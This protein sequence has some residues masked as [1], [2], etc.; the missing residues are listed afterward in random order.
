MP[1]KETARQSALDQSVEQAATLQRS[2]RLHEADRIYNAVLAADPQHFD[3]LHL[4]GVLKYQQGRAVEALRLVAAALAIRPAS[5]DALM[6]HGVVLEALKRHD[7]ALARFDQLLSA[8]DRDATLHYNRGKALQGLGRYAEALASYDR[9]IALAPDLGAAHQ[10]RGSTLAALDRDEDALASFDRALALVLAL[11]G[12]ATGDGISGTL[13]EG[14]AAML[15]EMDAALAADPASVDLLNNRGK[16]LFRL[17][18]HAEAIATFDRSL[19]LRSD[20]K[21]ALLGRGNALAAIDHFDAA[22]TDFLRALSI[23][24]N[25]ADAYLNLGNALVLVNR[26][27][28]ALQCFSAVLAINPENPDAHFNEGLVRLLLGD[29]RQGWHKYEYRWKRPRHEKDRPTFPQP[30]WR[31]EKDLAGRTI[32]LAPEQGLGD[33]IQF[34]RYAPLLDALGARVVVAA[35]PSLTALLATVPGVAEVITGGD[36]LPHFDLYCPLLSLPMGFE[37]ELATIPS[38]VPYIFPRQEWIDRW[39]VRSPKSSERLRVG[40]CWAGTGA[41][42]NNHRRSIAIEQFA[43]I[44]S[45]PGIDFVNLQKEVS[46]AESE[47]LSR[48]RVAQ[49][50]QEFADFAE[51]AAVMAMLDLVVSV[52]TSVAHLAGAMGKAVAVL[53][54]FSPDW[55]WLLDRTDSPWY[56]TMRLF[57]QSA[58]GDWD[59][60]LARLRQELE[61]VARRRAKSS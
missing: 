15:A 58:I 31:G 18:R 53:I 16:I 11:R 25:L 55:R 12:I 54:P 8:R 37:T 30:M 41:H 60:P 34:V 29:F 22:F 59:G 5:A 48:H 47:M 42:V 6:N 38:R 21:D 43:T 57:R 14:P 35:Q 4:S 2:G 46:A 44:L 45:V 33:A 27:E 20:Q 56:P 40:I 17:K 1:R 23:A 52:D 39:R 13:T 32:L 36:A 28:Q 19:A 10:N 61:V 26:T 9:A 49:L 50:G 7:E 3:A 24:P 51:T